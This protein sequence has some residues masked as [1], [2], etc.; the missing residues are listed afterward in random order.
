MMQKGLDKGLDKKMMSCS[1]NSEAVLHKDD[2]SGLQLLA[3]GKYRGWACRSH[4]W[5]VSASG[6]FPGNGGFEGQ[7]EVFVRHQDTH[8]H[9][10]LVGDGLGDGLRGWGYECGQYTDIR[11]SRL[12]VSSWSCGWERPEHGD[13]LVVC[14]LKSIVHKCWGCTG[15]IGARGRRREWGWIMIST[16]TGL[17]SDIWDDGIWGWF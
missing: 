17:A 1:A 15:C 7:N 14:G 9:T 12:C 6:D 11:L 13:L 4:M 10:Y 16:R 3:M 2:D 5:W 8:V